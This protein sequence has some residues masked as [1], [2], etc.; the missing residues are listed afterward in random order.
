MLEGDN[1]L[2][3]VL[4]AEFSSS[5]QGRSHLS[6]SV[7]FHRRSSLFQLQLG[8]LLRLVAGQQLSQS[9]LVLQL[10]IHNNVM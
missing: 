9:L 10:L 8:L 7:S 4:T 2:Q 5:Q 3:P 6:L 1:P